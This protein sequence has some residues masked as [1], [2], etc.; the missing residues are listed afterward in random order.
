MSEGEPT[1]DQFEELIRVLKVIGLIQYRVAQDRK[2][3]NFFKGA[4]REEI[5]DVVIP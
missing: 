2:G 5:E 1:Q 3:I 4:E